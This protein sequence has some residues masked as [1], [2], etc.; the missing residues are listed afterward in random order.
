MAKKF[1]EYCTPLN[2]SSQSGADKVAKRLTRLLNAMSDNIN[3]YVCEGP[4][5]EDVSAMRYNTHRRLQIDG[6]RVVGSGNGWKVS[7]PP[8]KLLTLA[9]FA[10]LDFALSILL[11]ELVGR[12][13]PSVFAGPGTRR[14]LKTT[15]SEL[16]ALAEA[17]QY[18]RPAQVKI[19]QMDGRALV[20]WNKG[21]AP[22]DEY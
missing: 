6:W 4:I 18:K 3:S 1:S 16:I 10:G 21:G 19:Y 7:P 9:D 22:T 20:I 15:D 8:T 17:E 5:V 14:A 12:G 11:T 13:A 2:V